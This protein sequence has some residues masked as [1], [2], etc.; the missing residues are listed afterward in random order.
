MKH[1]DIKASYHDIT[2][3]APQ[4]SIL[5]SLLFIICIKDLYNASNILQA[6]IFAGDTN[7][8]SFHCMIIDPFNHLN[9]ELNLVAV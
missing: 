8:F 9:L 5:G 3:G 1:K 2:C 6:I 4:G 7:L